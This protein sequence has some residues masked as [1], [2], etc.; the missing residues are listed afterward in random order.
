MRKA[1]IIGSVV[2]F[3][4]LGFFVLN[5]FVLFPFGASQSIS[6]SCVMP[7]LH[8]DGEDSFGL[9]DNAD[10]VLV[11][12][13]RSSEWVVSDGVINTHTEVLV[14]DVIMGSFNGDIITVVSPGGCSVRHNFCVSTSI[15]VHPVEGNTYLLFL[16][17]L[18][19]NLFGGFSSCGGIYSVD[20]GFVNCFADDLE[21]CVN[22]KLSLVDLKAQI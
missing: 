9:V 13:A 22:N 16:S 10:L 20:D 1:L 6:A 21:N 2:V 5:E 15:S 12:S 3:F 14:D 18:G 7:S 19:D 17:D 4:I 11:G 8:S